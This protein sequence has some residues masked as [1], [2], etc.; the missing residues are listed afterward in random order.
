VNLNKM[1][2]LYSVVLWVFRSPGSEIF[3]LPFSYSSFGFSLVVGRFVAA[4][5][6]S[7]RS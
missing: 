4:D 2:F 5:F 6:S 7:A 3:V 1:C